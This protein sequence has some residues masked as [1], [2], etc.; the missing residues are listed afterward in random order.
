MQRS[1]H[2]SYKPV[3]FHWYPNRAYA[4][5]TDRRGVSKGIAFGV[6]IRR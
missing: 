6:G 4:V 2:Y 5:D 3:L 1:T